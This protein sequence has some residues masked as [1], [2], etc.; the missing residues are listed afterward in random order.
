MRKSSKLEIDDLNDQLKFFKEE[1]GLL[2]QEIE[3]LKKQ[4][5]TYEN[6]MADQDT[7][8]GETTT[9][10]TRLLADNEEHQDQIHR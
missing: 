2:R 9:E 6:R 4:R 3:E 10:N 7:I 8:Y 5:D 1:D